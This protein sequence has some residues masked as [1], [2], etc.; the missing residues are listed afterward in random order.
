MLKDCFRLGVAVVVER[1]IPEPNEGEFGAPNGREGIETL[2][3]VEPPGL[4]ESE[5]AWLDSVSE[6]WLSCDGVYA[7]RR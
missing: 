1:L 6:G 2:L 7:G 5:L 4:G 3:L